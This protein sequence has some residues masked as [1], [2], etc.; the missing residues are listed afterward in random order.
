MLKV[1]PWGCRVAP[2]VAAS[3]T[4]DH[5]EHVLPVLPAILQMVERFADHVNAQPTDGPLIERERKG[6]GRML[7]WVERAAIILHLNAQFSGGEVDL[8]LDVMFPVIVVAV[9]EDVGEVFLQGELHFVQLPIRDLV[10]GSK[11]F[12]LVVRTGDFGRP[13]E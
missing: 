11:L 7:Q 10:G 6:W 4:F 9:T 2:F 3:K 5:Y 8:D 12:K 13:V 1:G